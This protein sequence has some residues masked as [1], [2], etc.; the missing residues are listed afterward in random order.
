M[1]PASVQIGYLAFTSV[2]FVALVLL[3]GAGLRRVAGALAS[4]AVFT[5]LS[6][7]IDLLAIRRGWWSYPGCA[8]PPHPP[9]PVYVGQALLFVGSIALIGWRVQRR[10]GARGVVWLTGLVC[11]AGAARDFG[12][13]AALPDIIQFGPL[14]SSLAAD[15]AAWLVV[16]FVALAVS[17]AVAGAAA[18]TR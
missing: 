9:L 1:F 18:A 14:P 15:V 6:A 11:V 2:V 12:V 7:P 8:D 17:R 10:F 16:V 4:V 3:T 13:A 5:A